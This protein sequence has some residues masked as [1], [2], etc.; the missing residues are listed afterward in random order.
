M[1]AAIR[2]AMKRSGD[3]TIYVYVEAEELFR[4]PYYSPYL[5]CKVDCH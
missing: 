2:E 3:N 1:S 4:F 5:S